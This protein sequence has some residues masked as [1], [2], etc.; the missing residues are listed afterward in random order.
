[1]AVRSIIRLLAAVFVF[2]P[3]SLA[4]AWETDGLRLRGRLQARWALED[5]LGD[6]PWADHLL[7]RR[8]R[9]DARW[10][11]NDMFRLVAELDLADRPKV[12]DMY[13][14][15]ELHPLARVTAGRFKKPVS[16][17]KMQSPFD[18]VV[19]ERGLLDR[20]AVANSYYGGYGGR[21]NGVMLSGVWKGP[22]K[23]RYYVGAFSN[24]LDDE[25]Y[26]RDYVGRIQVRILKGLVL[27]VSAN[28]KQYDETD[29]IGD[30]VASGTL[31]FFAADLRVALGGFRLQLEGAYGDNAGSDEGTADVVNTGLATA[32]LYGAHA[33]AS[34]RVELGESVALVPAV[35]VEVFDPNDQAEK[36][37]VLRLAAAV[38]AEIGD[39]LCIT[40]AGEGSDHPVKFDTPTVFYLQLAFML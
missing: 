27:G 15:V 5:Q 17:L 10:Q 28:H 2:L 24:L 30:P 1:M 3:P 19:P 12:K 18:L 40:L 26:H 38:N 21:D 22:V 16:R 13:A 34:Y 32:R 11:P 36:D 33:T 31:Q 20:Y 35:M 8:A 7:L 14:R 39:H 4:A 9:V 25:R 29:E 37:R 23:L 6:K